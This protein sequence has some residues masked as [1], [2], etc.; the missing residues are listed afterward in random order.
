MK[1]GTEIH[2]FQRMYCKSFN[3]LTLHLLPPSGATIKPT[4]TLQSLMP[5]SDFFGLIRSFCVADAADVSS[6]GVKLPRTHKFN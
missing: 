5:T 6:S 3:L 1:F 2:D 4:L